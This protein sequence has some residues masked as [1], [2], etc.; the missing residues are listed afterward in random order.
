MSECAATMVDGLQEPL[1][2]GLPE[3]HDGSHIS[4]AVVELRHL[5]AQLAAVSKERDEALEIVR[6]GVLAAECTCGDKKTCPNLVEFR[7]AR[8]I[9]AAIRGMAS[10]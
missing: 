7:K 4:Q 1:Y 10:A 8:S 6:L 9:L 2:C 3:G 5:R